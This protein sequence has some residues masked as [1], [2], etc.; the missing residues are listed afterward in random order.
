MINKVSLLG[1]LGADPESR[2][3][4]SGDPVVNLRLATS[5]KWKTKDGERVE[6]TEWH[7]VVIWNEHLAEIAAKYL[8]KGDLVYVEGQLQTRKWEKDGVDR[9][10][11][12]VVLQKFR[13]DLKLMPKAKDEDHHD[14]DRPRASNVKPKTVTR[15]EMIDDD[16][17][18]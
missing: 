1:R 6:K 12:E 9:Y 10:S 13:G 7:S 16:I 14:E 15:Q 5:E 3:L 2:R 11:T 17:P 8:H 4:T 18:F